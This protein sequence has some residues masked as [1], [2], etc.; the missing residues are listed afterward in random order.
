MFWVSP[1]IFFSLVFVASKKIEYYSK[2]II[3]YPINMLNTKNYTKSPIKCPL[4][5]ENK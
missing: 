2:V 3:D 1:I 4:K 5:E